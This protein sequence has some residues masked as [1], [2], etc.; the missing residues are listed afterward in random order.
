MEGLPSIFRVDDYRA[1][2]PD[3]QLEDDAAYVAHY[4]EEENEKGAVRL[5]NARQLVVQAEFGFEVACY[6]PYFKYLVEKGLFPPGR[7]V[8]TFAGMEPFYYFLAADQLETRRTTRTGNES[9]SWLLRNYDIV[10]RIDKSCWV[11][12]TYKERF[13]P[14]SKNGGKRSLVILNKRNVE[15]DKGPV[16]TLSVETVLAL[17]TLLTPMFTVVYIRPSPADVAAGFSHDFNAMLDLD[18]FGAIRRAFPSSED[19]ILFQDLLT[20]NAS[21]NETKCEVMAGA[22]DFIAV[23][24]GCAALVPF[25]ARR[26]I[27]LHVEGRELAA[28]HY[29]GY[30][31]EARPDLFE[32]VEVCRTEAAVLAAAEQMWTHEGTVT[33]AWTQAG[34][35][36]PA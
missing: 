33:G 4:L 32:R 1:L 22:D 21:Y 30:F 26:S 11:C 23:Q 25:F 20:A 29:D 24:G 27:V 16:N 8:S 36:E 28:G 9:G 31:K 14:K 18:D 34:T 2:N 10:G 3:L 17:L 35:A 5:I 6:V 7:R 13:A 19:V 15:W 12:P